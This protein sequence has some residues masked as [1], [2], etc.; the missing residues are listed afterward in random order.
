MQEE[1]NADA[2]AQEV[3]NAWGLNSGNFGLLS[4]DFK[5]LFEKTC[6]YRDAKRI[7]D[8]RREFNVLAAEEAI[9]EQR[10]RK[11]FFDAYRRFYEVNR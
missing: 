6:A 3:V 2:L 7:A 11:E 1:Q 8:N 5:A 9:N 10:A 4:T